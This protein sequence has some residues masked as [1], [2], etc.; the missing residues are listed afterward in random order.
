VVGGGGGRVCGG[1]EGPG[2]GGALG[3]GIRGPHYNF[4]L[5]SSTQLEGTG[6]GHTGYFEALGLL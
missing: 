1:G 3:H 2:G 5:G 4:N 6:P